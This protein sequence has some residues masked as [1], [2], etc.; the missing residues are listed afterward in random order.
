MFKLIS[1]IDVIPRSL[2]IT[3]V[4]KDP[5]AIVAGGFGNVFKGIHD[6]QLV[7]L[8]MLYK[9]HRAGVRKFSSSIS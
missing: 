1:K 2:F 3:D 6:G 4:E 5:H 9:G 7:A 8:K